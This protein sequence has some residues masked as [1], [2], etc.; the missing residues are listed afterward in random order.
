MWVQHVVEIIR[1]V[2][3]LEPRLSFVGSRLQVSMAAITPYKP[4]DLYL[5]GISDDLLEVPM[6][7][8]EQDIRFEVEWVVSKF[9]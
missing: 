9:V 3:S 7:S 6:C 4:F 5:S 1:S 8:K 2:N